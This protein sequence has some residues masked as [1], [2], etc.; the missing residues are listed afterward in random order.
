MKNILIISILALAFA[1]TSCDRD[2]ADEDVDTAIVQLEQFNNKF[3]E[4]NKDGV[5]SRDTLEGESKSEYDK[6]KKIASQYYETMNKINKN[7]KTEK[8]ELIEGKKTHGYEEVYNEALKANEAKIE[9]Q[10]K[11]FIENL[12]K[13]EK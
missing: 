4:Y 8:E 1:F 12:E 6:L 13:I 2:K 10:S 7:V 9:E 3:V 5:I 11:L